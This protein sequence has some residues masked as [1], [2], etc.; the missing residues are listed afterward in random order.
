MFGLL[1]LP[2][3]VLIAFVAGMFYERNAHTDRCL[4]AGGRVVDDLC[5][6]GQR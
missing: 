2:I 6:G 5:Q 4:D 3:L 1:R